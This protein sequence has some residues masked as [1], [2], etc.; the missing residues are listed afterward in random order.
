M[1]F[2]PPYKNLVHDVHC[3]IG[4]SRFLSFAYKTTFT[5]GCGLYIESQILI[6][7]VLKKITANAL[8]H[9]TQ[10]IFDK[11]CFYFAVRELN[12]TH[13]NHALRAQPTDYSL[14]C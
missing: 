14:I 13:G 4:L 5:L 3:E 7:I 10:F 11:P 1:N 6:Y 12:I 9:R 2:E 8:L